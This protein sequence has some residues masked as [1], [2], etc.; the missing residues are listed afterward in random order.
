MIIARRL[1]IGVFRCP[2]LLPPPYL[3]W[4]HEAV[5]IGVRWLSSEQDGLTCWSCGKLIRLPENSVQ[6][7][8]PCENRVVLPPTT[9]NYF[10]IMGWYVML[11]GPK[12][13][14]E[15]S[16]AKPCMEMPWALEYE[17]CHW[18]WRKTFFLCRKATS[19]QE[20]WNPGYL[21]WAASTLPLIWQLKTTVMF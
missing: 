7:F 12:P 10:E 11:T 6:F 4:G 21:A 8:C 5:C 19:C 16:G 3:S 2:R 9:D 20:S 13:S 14:E 18:H 1:S 15:G 17:Y